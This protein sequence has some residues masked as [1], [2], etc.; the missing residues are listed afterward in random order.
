M[1]DAPPSNA[2]VAA[3]LEKFPGPVELCG[4]Q[5]GGDP[6]LF[7]VSL[8]VIPLT[9][10][11]MFVA[12]GFDF[13]L[14]CAFFAFGCVLMAFGVFQLSLNSAGLTLD[15]DGFRQRISLFHTR[16]LWKNVSS[17]E[18][19]T[20]DSPFSGAKAGDIIWYHDTA[21]ESWRPH[22]IWRGRTNAGI[23][24]VLELSIEQLADLLKRWQDKAL[25]QE[26]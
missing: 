16:G 13:A 9:F 7:F 11:L 6:T 15:A 19:R 21:R 20:I 3:F 12:T 10:G 22:W 8:V 5:G 14:V 24:P 26:N 23:N 18:I 4:A 25:T 2:Q 17:F 1:I